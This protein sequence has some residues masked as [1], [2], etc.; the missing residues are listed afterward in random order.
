MSFSNVNPSLLRSMCFVYLFYHITSCSSTK[1]HGTYC[2]NSRKIMFF[3][4][5]LEE[6]N[7]FLLQQNF[8]FHKDWSFFKA[9]K[10]L[11]K[12]GKITLISYKGSFKKDSLTFL[13]KV[14]T[15]QGTIKR[16]KI[17]LFSDLALPAEQILR[18]RS[19]CNDQF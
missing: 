17:T 12:D 19:Q 1:I 9:G 10:Y 2:G 16:N 18:K 15:I 6:K 14:D 3:N 4:L 8:I 13:P 5:S 7:E 11:I